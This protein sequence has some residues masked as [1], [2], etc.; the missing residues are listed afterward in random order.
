MNKRLSRTELE[1]FCKMLVDRHN[2]L[3]NK[4]SQ[5]DSH[6]KN[7]IKKFNILK[8]ENDR[9][10]AENLNLKQEIQ[11]TDVYKNLQKQLKEAKARI[12]KLEEL[13]NRLIAENNALR[14]GSALD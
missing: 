11:K 1:V 6:C 14:N 3:K 4:Y 7:V 5:L 9:L 13:R 8:K 2:V 10:Q 12:R